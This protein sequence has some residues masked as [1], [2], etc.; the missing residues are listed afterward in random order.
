[1]FFHDHHRAWTL[2]PSAILP[3]LVVLPTAQAGLAHHAS[4]K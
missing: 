1:M 4:P 3:V 2:A